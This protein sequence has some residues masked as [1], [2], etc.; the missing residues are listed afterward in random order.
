MPAPD[1]TPTL[2]ESAAELKEVFAAL[3]NQTADETVGQT[4]R[5]V[6]N[7]PSPALPSVDLKTMEPPTKPLREAGEGVSAGLEP[8]TNSARRAFDLFLRELPPMEDGQKGL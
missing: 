5:L 6:S 7:V 8:V 2:R 3:T 4:K 1:K